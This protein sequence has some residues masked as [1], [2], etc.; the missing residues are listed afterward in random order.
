MKRS[1]K[2]SDTVEKTV[3]TLEKNLEWSQ[4][5]VKK[6]FRRSE[7]PAQTDDIQR[8]EEEARTSDKSFNA[9]YYLYKL[10][11]SELLNHPQM[12]HNRQNIKAAI[13]AGRDKLRALLKHRLPSGRY[14][15]EYVDEF[16]KS[17][18]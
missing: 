4:D 10:N 14:V 5:E 1:W 6:P 3:A 18:E 12:Q 2:P 11:E 16:N 15:V 13:E 7:T 8:R 17:N 9:F